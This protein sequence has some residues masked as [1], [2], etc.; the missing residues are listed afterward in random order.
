MS[1][2]YPHYL[3]AAA[4]KRNPPALVCVDAVGV[5]DP[6]TQTARYAAEELDTWHAVCLSLKGGSYGVSRSVSGRTREHWWGLLAEQV[7]RV[8]NSWVISC[9][10]PRVWSLLGLWEELEAERWSVTGHD[11]RHTD[12]SA[13]AMRAMRHDSTNQESSDSVGSVPRMRESKHGFLVI[14]DVPNVAMLSPC[15][16]KQ[17]CLWIDSRNHGVEVASEMLAGPDTASW[18]ADQF[19]QLTSA[20]VAFRLGALQATVGAQAMHGY[21]S[22]Y[23]YRGVYVHTDSES[24]RVERQSYFGGRCECFHIG[25]VSPSLAHLDFRS[26][27]ASVGIGSSVAIRLVR[28]VHNPDQADALAHC[29]AGDAI[30]RVSLETTENAYP[31]RRAARGA[32][33]TDSGE[34][35]PL[36]VGV[37]GDTDTIFPVGRF[38]TTL[39]GPELQDALHQGRIRHVHEYCQYEMGYALRDYMQAIYE[40]RLHYERAGAV[41]LAH[42][43]KR[44]LVSVPGKFGQRDRRWTPTPEIAALVPYG[45]WDGSRADGSPCRYRA[46]AWRTYRD[47]VLGWGA[48]SVPSIAAWVTS[49]ARVKLLQAIRVAGWGHVYYV[50]TDSLL[51]DSIGLDQLGIA[52][53]IRPGILGALYRKGEPAS[54]ALHGAKHYVEGGNVVCAGLPRGS[55]VDHG[56]GHHYWHQITPADAVRRGMRP[57]AHR[58]LRTY[59][60]REPYRQGIVDSDGKVMPFVLE[61]F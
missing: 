53:H 58:E 8:P 3:R 28:R 55:C 14:E 10:C 27:Y 59:Q 24:L 40:M 45:E 31:Y 41:G 48:E 29:D 5:T 15:G 39:C 6:V 25:T 49:A 37:N 42:Y 44:L 50:D 56:D 35:S 18:L 20:L 61:E 2:R 9:R 32:P 4:T 11:H 51:V 52:G 38:I 30:A 57:E 13:G 54:V 22:G 36:T 34:S 33:A 43:A 7:R 17:W 23:L 1:T 47:D 12:N 21:R 16:S 46:V 19:R 60:R 26:Q